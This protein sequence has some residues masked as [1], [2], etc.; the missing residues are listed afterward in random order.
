[1]S[2]IG[3]W[4]LLGALIGYAVQWV[5]DARAYTRLIKR[6]PDP[7]E[8]ERLRQQNQ[9]LA[10]EVAALKSAPESK[11]TTVTPEPTKPKTT[12]A[13]SLDQIDGLDPDQIEKLK[14]AGIT[15]PATL[16]T[17]TPD[18]ILA[19]LDAQ[20]WDAI[21]PEPWI[22][23]ART[24]GSAPQTTPTQTANTLDQIDGLEPD[25]IEKLKAAGITDPATLATKTPDEVLA[26]LDAQPWDAID[27]LPWIAQAKSLL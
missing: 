26:A 9:T 12:K 16:A 8:L 18:E 27:P 23:Q 19:A 5:L 11:P 10:D 4:I 6:L 20:P 21:D 13:G 15:D 25:Q 17:K 2:E 24:L 22:A 1:M 3:R 14:A 7:R